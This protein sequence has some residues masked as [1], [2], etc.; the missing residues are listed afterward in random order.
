MPTDETLFSS[1]QKSTHESF[2]KGGIRSMGYTLLWSRALIRRESH[3]ALSLLFSL[4]R[5]TPFDVE[6][7][8]HRDFLF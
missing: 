4:E 5:N 3:R 6:P 7:L 1:G 8:D 2:V